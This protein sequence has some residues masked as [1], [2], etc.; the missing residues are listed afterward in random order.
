MPKWIWNCF[1]I[2]CRRDVPRQQKITRMKKHQLNRTVV[3]LFSFS[4]SFLPSFATMNGSDQWTG[5]VNRKVVSSVEC[6]AWISVCVFCHRWNIQPHKINFSIFRLSSC[7]SLFVSFTH[8]MNT[9]GSECNPS[10]F[11]VVFDHLW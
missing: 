3:G 7:S 11:N 2:L 10:A 4:S 6:R 5:T 9:T 8:N 1:C